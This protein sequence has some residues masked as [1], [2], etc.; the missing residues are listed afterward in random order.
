MHCKHVTDAFADAIPQ[1][2]TVPIR[3]TNDDEERH[4]LTQPE[5]NPDAL[6]NVY[7]IRVD[8]PQSN[9]VSVWHGHCE[10]HANTQ[11]HSESN[12]YDFA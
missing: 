5:S 2:D 4:R 6:C 8:E 11:W 7:G 1:S 12:A 10:P 3:V 9:G